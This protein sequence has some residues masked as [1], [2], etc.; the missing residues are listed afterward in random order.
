MSSETTLKID[1]EFKFLIPT[2]QPIYMHAL[3]QSIRSEGC[4]EPITVW[5]T[6]I[7][8]GH[9]RYEI[10]QKYDIPFQTRTIYCRNRQ[11]AMLWICREQLA[12][13]RINDSYKRYLIGKRVLL[14]QIL[15]AHNA[16]GTDQNMDKKHRVLRTFSEKEE[17]YDTSLVRT[18]EKL[19]AE[20]HLNQLTVARYADFARSIDRICAYKP[21]IAVDILSERIRITHKNVSLIG[22]LSLQEFQAACR[23]LEDLP[24]GIISYSETGAIAPKSNRKTRITLPSD[25]GSIKEMPKYDP[26]AELKSLM[27]TIPSWVSSIDR[28]LSSPR[29]AEATKSGKA[30]LS[31]ELQKLLRITSR[32][33]NTLKEGGDNE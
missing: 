15:A 25:T 31:A 6:T 1:P 9:K 18:R 22:E 26:D 13:H 17:L 3:E 8:D 2:A 11:E 4:K 5:F 7:L 19:G 28:L 20:Y 30:S 21:D 33:L 32:M 14:E 27:F 23:Q 29:L 10:C 24:P 12:G 16:A